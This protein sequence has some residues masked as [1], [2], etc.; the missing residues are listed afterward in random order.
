[1]PPPSRP[2]LGQ[3]TLGELL[4][5]S[6]VY[7]RLADAEVDLGVWLSEHGPDG[8]RVRQVELRPD[9]TAAASSVADWPMNPPFDLADPQFASNEISR[10]EFE[11]AW[12]RAARH[13]E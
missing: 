11:R 7:L 1:V 13:E 5:K 10:E 8:R 9:G 4:G 2:E 3:A 12:E 6:R